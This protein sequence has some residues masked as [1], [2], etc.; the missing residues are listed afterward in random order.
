MIRL[1]IVT[2]Q[3]KNDMRVFRSTHQWEMLLHIFYISKTIERM[4]NDV[5]II[6]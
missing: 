6:K 1:F 3:V 5:I 4:M 2:S